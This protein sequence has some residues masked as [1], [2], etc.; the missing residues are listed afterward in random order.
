VYIFSAEKKHTQ[1]IDGLGKYKYHLETSWV[2]WVVHANS[3]D[4][5]KRILL[6]KKGVKD[7]LFSWRELK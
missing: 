2:I 6:E 5:A 3:I 4:D 7:I 1:E